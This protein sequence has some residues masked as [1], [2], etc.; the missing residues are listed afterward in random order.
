MPLEYKSYQYRLRKHEYLLVRH[1]A[2]LYP[3]MS[4]EGKHI[5][6]EA[7]RSACGRKDMDLYPYILRGVTEDHC[8]CHT[9]VLDGMPC[10]KDVYYRIR[11]KFYWD[12]YQ[13]AKET[14]L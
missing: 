7:M 8:Y 9:L 11:R 3:H 5:I 6:E 2:L 4:K 1:Y 12:L 10:G 13:W 14:I